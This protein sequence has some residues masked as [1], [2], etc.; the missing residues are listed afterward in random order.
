MCGVCACGCVGMCMRVCVQ[1]QGKGGRASQRLY[2]YTYMGTHTCMNIQVRLEK[3]LAD[4]CDCVYEHST[5]TNTVSQ[6]R[7]V[8]S[9]CVYV[10]VCVCLFVPCLCIPPCHMCLRARACA[11]MFVCMLCVCVQARQ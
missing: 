6:H 9:V 1:I 10:R 2:T 8:L 5:S 4:V 11:R 3:A 7:G